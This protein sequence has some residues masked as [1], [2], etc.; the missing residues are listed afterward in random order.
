MAMTTLSVPVPCRVSLSKPLSGVIFFQARPEIQYR[1]EARTI[2]RETLLFVFLL[3]DASIH[4][5]HGDQNQSGDVR[6]K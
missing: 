4:E 6:R 1:T 2:T 3:E 5:P